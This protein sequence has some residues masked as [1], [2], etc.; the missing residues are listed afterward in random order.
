MITSIEKFWQE[1][2]YHIWLQPFHRDHFFAL[3]TASASNSQFGIRSAESLYCRSN[4]GIERSWSKKTVKYECR[5]SLSCTHI[6]RHVSLLGEY[7]PCDAGWVRGKLLGAGGGP[8]QQSRIPRH[9]GHRVL[10]RPAGGLLQQHGRL[11]PAGGHQGQHGMKLN[12]TGKRSN[13]QRRW[14]PGSNDRALTYDY[15][16]NKFSVVFN[17]NDE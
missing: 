12:V 5:Q 2:Q 13:T 16:F 17:N 14:R 7:S 6:L 8:R 10:G 15:V 1:I 9:R 11:Y 4:N 3:D